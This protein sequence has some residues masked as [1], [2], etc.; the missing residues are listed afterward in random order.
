M[1]RPFFNTPHQYIQRQT[2]QVVTEHLPGDA[3]LALLYTDLREH[4]PTLFKA[5]TSKHLTRV[6]GYLNYDARLLNQLIDVATT[7]RRLGIDLTECLEA[8]QALKTRRHLFERKIRYWQVRPLAADPC[9]VVAPADARLLVGALNELTLLPVK[10]KFFNVAELLGAPEY[11]WHN[12]FDGGDVA[13]LRLT[14]DKYHYNHAPVSGRVMDIYAVE[15]T[16]HACNPGAV[17][18]VMTPFSKNRRVIT[19]IDTDTPGGTQVGCV[20]LV[21]VVAMMI[22]TVSQC[23]SLHFY[24]DPRDVRPGTWLE[25]GAPKSL[26]RPGSSTTM[27]LF[28]RGR[29]EFSADIRANRYRR[30][31]QSRFSKGFN[32]P[33]VE[34]DVQV[35]AEMARAI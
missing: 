8:P 14:P 2:G 17:I 10:G 12:R 7:A 27:V 6:L 28:E 11:H 29:I 23:Y 21:E 35:R 18:S 22:G 32:Q 30:D 1:N 20:A 13:I 9:Q 31:V 25:K 34:T 16:Y 15:G 33:L 26:Y 24:D 5:L 4:A 19:L 3:L